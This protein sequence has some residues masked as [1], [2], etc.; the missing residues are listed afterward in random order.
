VNLGMVVVPSL[1]GLSR[2]EAGQVILETGLT[3]GQV[4]SLTPSTVTVMA[5]SPAAGTEVVAGT[6]VQLTFEGTPEPVTVGL[7]GL[8]LPEETCGVQIGPQAQLT[9]ITD[10]VVRYVVCPPATGST[11]RPTAEPTDVTSG[12]TFEA[13]DRALRLPDMPSTATT[14]CLTYLEGPIVVV[15][16][17]ASGA[18]TVHLPDDGC[19]HRRPEVNAALP[20][21]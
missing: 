9:A 6:E 2:A 14:L 11:A 1:I 18:W 7:R 21:A 19:G 17:T 15:A 16:V 20:V 4:S 8:F 13:L 10:P 3:T 12:A 5:Q